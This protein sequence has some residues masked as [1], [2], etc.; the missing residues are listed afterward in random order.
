MDPLELFRELIRRV[1]E[2]AN[3]GGIATYNWGRPVIYIFSRITVRLWGHFR[4][5]FDILSRILF[6]LYDDFRHY[7]VPGVVTYH[8]FGE[9][10]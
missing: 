6:V 8:G 2:I 10:L 9:G 3:G 4:Q 1:C 5:G 7:A